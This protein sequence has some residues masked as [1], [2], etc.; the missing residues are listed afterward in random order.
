MKV[1]Q[2]T[3]IFSLMIS[4]CRGMP[5]QGHLLA[6]RCSYITSAEILPY[7]H[8]S[9]FFDGGSEKKVAKLDT[10]AWIPIVRVLITLAMHCRQA[11][12]SNYFWTSPEKIEMKKIFLPAL[13]L[14]QT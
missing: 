13:S 7:S 6:A 3:D 9:F 8:F 2:L 4:R 1:Q 12:Q 5:L 10:R 14:L 11:K